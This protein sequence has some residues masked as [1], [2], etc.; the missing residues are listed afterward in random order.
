MEKHH[1]SESGGKR[2]NMTKCKTKL[3]GHVSSQFCG[4]LHNMF[5]DVFLIF[6]PVRVEG[7]DVNDSYPIPRYLPR[8]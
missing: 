8:M 2:Q 5:S 6:T 7:S 1:S 4:G 3:L